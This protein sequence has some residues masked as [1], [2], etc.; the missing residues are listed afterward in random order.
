VLTVVAAVVIAFLIFQVG[1]TMTTRHFDANM[2]SQ[3]LS[4]QVNKQVPGADAQVRCPSAPIRSGY[5]FVCSVSGYVSG[6]IGTSGSLK[7][8]V[9]NSNGDLQWRVMRA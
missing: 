4:A 8:T 3:N 7:V 1:K 6:P 2:L 9:L 5:I